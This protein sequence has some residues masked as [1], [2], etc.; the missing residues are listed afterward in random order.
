LRTDRHCFHAVQLDDPIVIRLRE[1]SRL[2]D[3]LA[4]EQNRAA[5]QLWEQLHRF[6]PQLLQLSPST[7]GPWLWDLL[8]TAPS[9]LQ[10]ARLSSAKIAQILRR[11]RIR[12]L[13][14]QQIQS[15]LGRKPLPL[16]PGA[17][18]AA[19]EHAL[20]L[21]PRLRLLHQQRAQIAKHLDAWL[22]KLA[23]PADTAAETHEHRDAAILLSCRE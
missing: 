19:S 3:N 23:A 9:P 6:F 4:A 16:A 1:L 18:E 2:E 11:H 5:N 20:L 14:P 15:V 22:Q 8:Q 17:A 12:R 13:D 21:L 7:N 10:A